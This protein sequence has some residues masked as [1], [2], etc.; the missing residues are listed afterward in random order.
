[1]EVMK[2]GYLLLIGAGDNSVLIFLSIKEWKRKLVPFETNVVVSL[3]EMET[4]CKKGILWWDDAN[5]CLKSIVANCFILAVLF[6]FQENG[7]KI[8]WNPL[9]ER[10]GL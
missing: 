3:K 1:M 9:P 8:K 7:T 4:I 2:M 5:N 6:I 10:N